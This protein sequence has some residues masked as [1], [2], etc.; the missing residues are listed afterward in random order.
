MTNQLPRVPVRMS[1]ANPILR[2]P[3][4]P[5]QTERTLFR[6]VQGEK[7]RL[8]I[9]LQ[10]RPHIVRIVDAHLASL[11][12]NGLAMLL[13][14]EGDQLGAQR[15][16]QQRVAAKVEGLAEADVG[17]EEEV[18]RELVVVL[19]RLP[20]GRAVRGVGF[21][22]GLGHGAAEVA[23]DVAGGLAFDQGQR[24]GHGFVQERRP[25]AE[26]RV[27][28][29]Y[30]AALVELHPGEDLDGPGAEDRVGEVDDSRCAGDVAVSVEGRDFVCG[31]VAEQR[32][33]L[34]VI[35]EFVLDRLE[36]SEEE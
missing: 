30:P 33:R 4:V 15:A 22:D 8:E 19:A 10:N 18:A 7:G 26:R 5:V 25:V 13:G 36:Q 23:D 29:L 14:S 21:A 27:V 9:L 1:L 32:D 35:G 31:W 28:L 16:A 34:L 3:R 17:G 11:G 12:A 6:R 20:D 24:R 2:T